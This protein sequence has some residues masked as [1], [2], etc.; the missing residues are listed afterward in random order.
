MELI[1]G[2]LLLLIVAITV[3]Q[4]TPEPM[5]LSPPQSA[6]PRAPVCGVAYADLTDHYRSRHYLTSTDKPCQLPRAASE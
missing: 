3:D 5:P 6:A 2:L 4:T 1:T